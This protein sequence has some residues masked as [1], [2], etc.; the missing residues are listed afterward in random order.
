MSEIIGVI[1]TVEGDEYQGKEF[2][3]V[4]LDS[5]QVLKVKYGREGALKAKWN[6]LQEGATVKFTM[7]DYTK[8][9]GVKVPFVSNIAW[10]T[11]ELSTPRTPYPTE[12]EQDKAY[13]EAA[14]QLKK[15]DG[16]NRSFALAYIKDIVVALINSGAIQEMSP[17]HY[18]EMLKRAEIWARWLDG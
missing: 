17:A 1:A 15:S 13:G 7:M 16:K 8:P 2:K 6:L 10:L 11:E 12:Q 14:T 18:D 9:D 3:K 5:G 4:T